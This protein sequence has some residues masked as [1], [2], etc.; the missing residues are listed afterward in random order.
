MATEH[1][2][3]VHTAFQTRV[4]EEGFGHRGEQGDSG[5]RRFARLGIC[6]VLG[7]V[8]LGAYVG[9]QGAAALVQRLHGQQHAAYVG[10]VDD[11]IGR[12]VLCHW[13]AGRAAL[14]PVAGIGYRGLVGRFGATDALDA[15]GQALI[16]HH[17]EHRRQAFVGLADQPAGGA[18]EVH[19]AG[20]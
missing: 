4:G 17:G 15:D 7:D 6:A 12:L 19:H 16:V 1:L 9:G 5:L 20:G 3:A 18:I 2:L 10:V 8:Q 11:R 14:Q 13:T